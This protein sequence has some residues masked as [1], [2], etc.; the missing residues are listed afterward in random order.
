LHNKTE[1][2][3]YN[4]T[5]KVIANTPDLIQ[6]INKDFS[7]FKKDL[8]KQQ[9][10]FNFQF[11]LGDIPWNKLPKTVASKQS[12]NSITYR[13]GA[14]CYNN[15]YG[16]ALSIYNFSTDEA[17]IYSNSLDR[18]HEISYLLILSRTGKALDKKGIHKIHAFG[19]SQNSINIIGMMPMKGGKTSLFLDLI[20]D[21]KINILSDD[22]PLVTRSGRILPFPIRVGMEQIPKRTENNID[23]QKIY[24]IN[25]KQYGIKKLIPMYAFQNSIGDGKGTIVLFEGKR[26]SYDEC[27]IEKCSKLA[28]IGPLLKH[29]VVG[30]G[31]PLILEYF[32][33]NTFKDMIYNFSILLSRLLAMMSLLFRAKTYNAY[34]GPDKELNRKT[35]KYFINGH[36]HNKYSLNKNQLNR[37]RY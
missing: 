36:I 7:Y 15:Y 6:R 13:E 17:V 12:F 32:L 4:I 2:D 27:K 26:I 19:I 34:L 29:M 28:M 16:E 22:T 33:E 11:F 14:I 9:I 25:R 18:L 24:T 37:E 20:D 30:M 35:I 5:L 8:I 3:F 10:Q 31:L 1:F 21:S 23:T